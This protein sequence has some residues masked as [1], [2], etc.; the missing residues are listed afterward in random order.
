MPQ[1]LL[2]SH[3]CLRVILLLDLRFSGGV[4]LSQV[5]RLQKPAQI[6][7]LSVINLR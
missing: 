5:T 2:P 6:R 4:I 7:D 3:T 1:E